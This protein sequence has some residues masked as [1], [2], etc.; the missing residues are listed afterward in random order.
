MLELVLAEVE[1][2]VLQEL[3]QLYDHFPLYQY[4]LC[5]HQEQLLVLGH[6]VL[7]AEY[8]IAQFLYRHINQLG[9]LMLL[10]MVRVLSGQL[11]SFLLLEQN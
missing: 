10:E 1:Q 3:V 5:Y 11:Y 6:S 2:M 9:Y 7:L 4:F 8:I